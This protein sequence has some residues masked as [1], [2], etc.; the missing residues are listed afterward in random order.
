M[1]AW[2]PSHPS[3]GLLGLGWWSK[4][5]AQGV[6]GGTLLR[7]GLLAAPGDQVSKAEFPTEVEGHGSALDLERVLLH[8]SNVG[9]TKLKT[10]FPN[11]SFPSFLSHSVCTEK[12]RPCAFDSFTPEI[13]TLPPLRSPVSQEPLETFKPFHPL[14]KPG[15]CM[16]P[17]ANECG[18]FQSRRK[19]FLAGCS[20]CSQGHPEQQPRSPEARPWRN[21]RLCEDSTGCR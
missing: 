10:V 20:Q 11:F 5:R 19:A 6:G 7:L 15:P 13:I 3:F 2:S 9:S 18:G 21:Q 12:G 14:F 4:K 8:F 16:L 1:L 17:R